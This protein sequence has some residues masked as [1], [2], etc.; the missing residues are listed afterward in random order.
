MTQKYTREEIS[1]QNGRDGKDCWLIIKNSVYNVTNY[2]QDHPGG[3]DLILEWAGK[4][5]T[6]AFND[7]GHSTDALR[8]LKMLKI[9]EV[10]D[11][12]I[13]VKQ[14]KNA[15]ENIRPEMMKKK[16]SRECC[17]IC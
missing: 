10:V 2:L 8:D 3:D 7:F 4:D 13:L 9:G 6:K 1:Q 5:G 12:K 11:E 17:F 16:S 14:S 15:A